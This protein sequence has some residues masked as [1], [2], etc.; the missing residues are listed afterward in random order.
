LI[1][2]LACVALPAGVSADLKKAMAENNLEKRSR[3]ALQNAEQALDAARKAYE[4]GDLKQTQA[5]ADEILASVELAEESLRQTGKD[6]R[7]KPKHFKHAEKQTR[8]LL[9][10]IES[11]E[12]YMSYTDRPVIQKLKERTHEIHDDLLAGIM[13][14][15]R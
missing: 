6:P 1:T 5:K 15:K 3:L 12:N 4:S 11:L 7:R 2:L 9:R 14:E 10:G 8:E 13:G